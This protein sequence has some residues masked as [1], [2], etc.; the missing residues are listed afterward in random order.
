MM[1]TFLIYVGD[2]KWDCS[3]KIPVQFPLASNSGI[4]GPNVLCSF[5]VDG[6][7]PLNVKFYFL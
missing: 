7:V 1:L 5:I 3:V 2:L 4:L 6:W